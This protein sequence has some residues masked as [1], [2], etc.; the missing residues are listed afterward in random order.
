MGDYVIPAISEL[1]REND[2]MVRK[3]GILNEFQIGWLKK[4]ACDQT[5]GFEDCMT[6]TS[7][8]GLNRIKAR[9]ATSRSCIKF[10]P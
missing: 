3:I 10:F 6:E 5:P 1:W 9:N 2:D 4:I 7:F 8:L